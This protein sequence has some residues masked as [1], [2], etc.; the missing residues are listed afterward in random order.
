MCR[1][2]PYHNSSR[3][4]QALWARAE[5]DKR[6]STPPGEARITWPRARL[7]V[8]W[9]ALVPAALLW[10]AQPGFTPDLEIQGDP[11]GRTTVG[12]IQAPSPGVW[13]L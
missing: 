11:A 1:W 8:P 9:V 3:S 10:Y 5:M 13:W 2:E 12:E 7:R 4:T 6:A